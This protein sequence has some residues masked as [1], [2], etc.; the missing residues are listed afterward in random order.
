MVKNRTKPLKVL[1][2]GQNFASVINSLSLGFDQ[3]EG[4]TA[5]AISLDGL[6]SQYNSYSNYFYRTV[7]SST[8]KLRHLFSKLV[9]LLVFIYLLCWCDI[10]HVYFLPSDTRFRGLE[11]RLIKIFCKRRVVTFLGSEVRVPEISSRDNLYYKDAYSHPDY[12]Y[13]NESFELS[14]Y[15]QQKYAKDNYK[16]IVWDVEGYIDR[17]LFDD[18]R[19]VPHASV[20][21][22][23]GH[24]SVLKDYISVV[25]APS[26]PVA[27]GSAIIAEGIKK[28]L[29][30]Y[31]NVRFTR[32]SGISNLE[33]QK[34][35][36]ES[37][38]LIDQVIWGAYGVAAQ[39]AM[40]MGKVVCAYINEERKALYGMDCPIIN[41]TKETFFS[42]LEK[43][44][45][46]ADYM[47][48]VKKSSIN[49]Y[50][51]THSPAAVAERMK[52]AYISFFYGY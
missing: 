23:P 52:N 2:I 39:Q 20:N 40:E 30:V 35:L 1:L 48:K 22:L 11:Q 25:H 36:W 10:V 15:F 17:K 14:Q 19:I 27:K 28:I 34:K 6:V 12:E 16:L 49:Y 51:K 37:D 44:I 7:P 41:I 8:S 4:V 43:L 31:P 18:I 13:K 5:R 45:L 3:T 26:A 29:E 46:D 42:E 50:Q 47:N 9:G 21:T 32:L 24:Q 38:I 33:Y